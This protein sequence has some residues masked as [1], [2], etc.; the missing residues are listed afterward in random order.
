MALFSLVILLLARV[1]RL[2]EVVSLP[3]E[4]SCLAGR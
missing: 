4:V 3:V 1:L 2:P